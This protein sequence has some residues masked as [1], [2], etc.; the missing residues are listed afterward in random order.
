MYLQKQKNYYIFST[1]NIGE[2]LEWEEEGRGEGRKR[3]EVLEE[4]EE[5]R[6]EG[7]NELGLIDR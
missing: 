1:S 2:D 3:S 6:E 4:R 7:W 5:E